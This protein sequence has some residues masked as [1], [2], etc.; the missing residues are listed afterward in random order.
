MTQFTETDYNLSS[1]LTKNIDFLDDSPTRI[2]S[3]NLDADCA[4]M[5]YQAFKEIL[6]KYI[7]PQFLGML[8]SS[9]DLFSSE[10]IS[11]PKG[12]FFSAFHIKSKPTSLAYSIRPKYYEVPRLLFWEFNT[13]AC[14]FPGF[15]IPSHQLQGSIELVLAMMISSAKNNHNTD[16]EIP[17]D[18]FDD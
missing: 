5:Q 7:S 16:A 2:I 8:E 4:S 12:I 14:W 18:S 17:F 10:F 3:D 9:N 6:L 15:K 11:N 13:Y 1:S